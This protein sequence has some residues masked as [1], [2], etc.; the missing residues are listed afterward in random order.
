MQ[1]TSWY[2]DNFE[3]RLTGRYITIKHILPLLDS[4]RNIFNVSVAGF[5]EMGVEI[6][7][8]TLGKGAKK[9]LIWSQMHGNES[10]TTKA[11]F[12]FFKY[13]SVNNQ[14]TAQLLSQYSF[15]VLPILNPDGAALYTRENANNIDLNRDA[16]DVSQS[17]SRVLRS[18][19]DSLQPHL[20]LNM[21]D[22]RSIFGIDGPKP[23][24]LSFLAPSADA[25]KTITPAREIAMELIVKMKNY[26]QAY[27][28]NQIGRFDDTFN[29]NCVGDSFTSSGSP[30]ILFEA[31]HYPND[32]SREQS[33]SFVF[34]ALIALFDLDTASQN[35]SLDYKEYF[36]I[37]ENQKIYKDVVL[38]N[39]RVDGEDNLQTI[40][41]QYKEKLLHQKIEFELYF[42]SMQEKNNVFG[43][44]HFDLQ[45]GRILVNSHQ[46]ILI[47][48]KTATIFDITQN[49]MLI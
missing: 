17:E 10:T 3:D 5:S 40:S 4:Y 42:D 24:T 39:V 44:Q 35:N 23:A 45:G 21:H 43:H 31:G 34:Y 41:F 29:Q 19:F 32:Y 18:I 2:T 13:I 49:L 6:P 37:P 1:I 8:V 11:L 14:Q 25:L 47:D 46:N 16:E 26:I 28:H 12:D 22:Q 30:T 20:C 9:V 38:Y 48:K 36:T 27:H 33:R 7:L 15:Y